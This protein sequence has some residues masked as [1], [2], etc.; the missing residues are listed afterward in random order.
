MMRYAIPAV[1]GLILIG[2][3]LS[4]SYAETQ[5]LGGIKNHAS[6]NVHSPAPC[7]VYNTVEGFFTGTTMT[8]TNH[9]LICS[10]NIAGTGHTITWNHGNTGAS[11]FNPKTSAFTN[12]WQDVITPTGK[13]TLTCIFP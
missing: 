2:M 13:S 3:T 5:N 11:C 12:A 10:G 8:N 9:L 6:P 7:N 1:L 4:V